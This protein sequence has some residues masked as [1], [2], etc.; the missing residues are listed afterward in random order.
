MMRNPVQNVLKSS[1]KCCEILCI[2][3]SAFECCASDIVRKILPSIIT[4]LSQ[5]FNPKKILGQKLN[6]TKISTIEQSEHDV[7]EKYS[8]VS[9]IVKCQPRV[10]HNT[11]KN[12]TDLVFI[13]V[14]QGNDNI[15]FAMLPAQTSDFAKQSSLDL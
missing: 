9:T 4:C 15:I 3:C 8:K 5:L 6:A 13:H 7:D 1:A 11:S 12:Y 10:S 14:N 2:L